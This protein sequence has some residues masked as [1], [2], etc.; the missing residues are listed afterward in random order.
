MIS[1]FDWF[2][3]TEMKSMYFIVVHK[4]QLGIYFCVHLAVEG[5]IGITKQHG[6]VKLYQ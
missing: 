3:D 6:A 1:V 5:T 2:N 4:Q